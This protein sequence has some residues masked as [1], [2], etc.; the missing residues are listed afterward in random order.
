MSLKFKKTSV[1]LLSIIISITFCIP[2]CVYAASEEELRS[3]VVSVASGE[4]GYTG[5][6]TNSKYGDWF[7]YQGGWCTTFVLWCFNQVGESSNTK[8]N[9]VIIPRGGNCNSMI[10]WFKDKGRYYSPSDYTPNQ[11]DLVFFDWNESGSC[12]HVGI[13]N[14]TSGSTVYTIEGNCSGKVKAREYTAKGSKPYNNISAII[15]YASPN[16]ASVS[17]QSEQTTAQSTTAKPTTKKATTTKK[18]TTKKQTTTKKTTTT[19]QTTT[20]HT[21]TTATTKQTTAKPTA[22]ESTTRT[23]TQTTAQTTTEFT[24]ESTT[25]S[26][27]QASETTVSLTNLSIYA[28]NYD[29]QVGDSVKLEYS[30]EPSDVKAVVGYFCDQEGIIEI[31][32]GG[33]IKAI[34][35]GTATVVVCANDDLYAQCD[36]NVTDAVGEVSTMEN[37]EERKVVATRIDVST[38]Q[39]NAQSVLTRLGVNVNMLTQNKQLYIVPIS[40]A[41]VTAFVSIFIALVK[42]IKKK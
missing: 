6:S 33:E 40:I 5:T 30:V 42:K 11:G 4:V 1:L 31:G 36:F 10:S 22:K 41:G 13:V 38:T 25:V 21:T 8:L 39:A 19:K 17:G 24:T 14:Y 2:S 28:S 15:G 37:N 16:Y 9:G 32:A 26:T 29:L 20:K 12:D 34:G 3:S 35:T 7:G 23:T 18:P 27:F